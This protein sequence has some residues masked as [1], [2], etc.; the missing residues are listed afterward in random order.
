MTEEW[1]TI[2]SFSNYEASSIGRIRRA[3]PYRSTTVGYVLRPEPTRDGYLNARLST[4]SKIKC[5]GIHRLVCEAFR[6]PAPSPEHE[7]AHWDGVR[8]NNTEDNLRWA[9]QAENFEDRYRHGTE[10]VGEKNGHA[11]LTEEDVNLIRS[12]I[13][14][15]ESKASLS[16]LYGVSDAHISRIAA[17]KAWSHLEFQL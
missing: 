6:G 15:G 17:G 12:K 10:P 5:V 8:N 13:M 11:K 14:F 4:R 1:R 2:P 7:A 16:R 3:A 9:T